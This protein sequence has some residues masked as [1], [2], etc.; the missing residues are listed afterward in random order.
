MVRP[1]VTD[2]FERSAEMSIRG[3]QPAS[4]RCMD[5]P[6]ERNKTYLNSATRATSKIPELADVQPRPV[7]R[8]AVI[9]MGT[10][11][12]GIAQALI[13]AGVAVVAVDSDHSAL[14]RG[15]ARIERS[16]AKRVEQGRLPSQ[17]V[18]EIL[19]LLRT[20]SNW[21]EIAA[22]DAVIESVFEDIETKQPI[23]R[24]AEQ[25]CSDAT[26]VATNTSTISLDRLSE[27]MARPHHL[28]GMHFFNPAQ[29]MPLVEIIRREST[30][31]EVIATVVNL[32]GQLRK[33]PVVVRNREGFLV[34]RVFIPYLQEAFSL[35]EEGAAAAAIDAAA[36]RFGFP[37]G[38]LVLIDMAGLDILV[39]AQRVL[40]HALPHH[41]PL[42]SVAT[43]LV[44]DGHLGQKTGAGVY[45]YEPGDHTPYDHPVTA[46]IVAE[47]Q[48]H[49]GRK[50]REIGHVEIT[51][52]LVL[53]M[54]NEAF[55][56]VR[57]GVARCE[58]DVDVA[59]VLGTGFPDY[60][61]GIL[62]YAEDIGL[63][64]VSARLEELNRQ[65]GERFLPCRP[66]R[67]TKGTS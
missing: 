36:V 32:V 39:H 34:N 46:R 63:D 9:G 66:K 52:R 26:I 17:R 57:E 51:E 44:E 42:S 1:H 33:T 43:R 31:S 62:K 30:P 40:D 29:R 20:T 53:R 21:D 10:M 58:A 13:G 54:V 12:S 64:D 24:R 45:R 22:A 35:L 41:G 48:R 16:L 25:I 15:H 59:M 56:V 4:A 61:G 2:G 7:R 60:R 23:L 19:G 27:G 47:V 8:A 38:P 55:Y 37:M 50:P 5:T 18:G 3:E 67:S 14:Q 65:C 11:G 49:N 28:V 6:A